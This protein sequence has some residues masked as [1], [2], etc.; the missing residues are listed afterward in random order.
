MAGINPYESPR[1]DAGERGLATD[2][3][4]TL[5]GATMYVLLASGGGFL[6]GG[7]LGLAIGV[8]VPGY[9][10]TVFRG[11]DDP[12]FNPA[13]TGTLLGATQGL[14]GGALVGCVILVIYVW[15][16]TRLKRAAA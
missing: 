1:G 9:Y 3:R 15:Y 11:A 7:L 2:N 13:V 10:R 4:L 6:L 5:F 14:F 16:L 8:L 12:A